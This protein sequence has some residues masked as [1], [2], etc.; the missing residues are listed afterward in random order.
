[1]TK[2]DPQAVFVQLR[3]VLARHEPGLA[4]ERD[5][6]DAYSLNAAYSE[7][8]KKVIFFGS[9]EIRRNYVSYHLFPVYMF[10]ELLAGMSPE[11]RA[12]MQGKSCFNFRSLTDE[13][14]TEIA[15]LTDRGY[16][17]FETEGLVR[18]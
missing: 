10:P 2:S 8:W 1:L 15:A 12:R 9:A 3:S 16:R 17:R 13:Q 18:A 7:Q 6:A 14:L 11:L 4:V 5:T